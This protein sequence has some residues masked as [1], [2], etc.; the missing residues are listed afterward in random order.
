MTACSEYNKATERIDND[1]SYMNKFRLLTIQGLQRSSL[2]VLIHWQFQLKKRHHSNCQ[3][4]SCAPP[5]L[6]YSYNVSNV[7]R[8]VSKYCNVIIYRLVCGFI[9]LLKIITT[10]KS[11]A[12]LFHTT[13]LKSITNVM[14]LRTKIQTFSRKQDFNIQTHIKADLDGWNSTMAMC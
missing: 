4:S 1:C 8:E 5:T 2:V 12:I 13:Q 6:K 10:R 11:G 14:A 9:E 7:S 3:A